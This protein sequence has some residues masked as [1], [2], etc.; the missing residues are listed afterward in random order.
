LAAGSGKK[1]L[2]IDRRPHIGVM[3][4]ISLIPGVLVHKYGRISSTNS[5]RSL[6]I[7]LF[8]PMA[9][10]EHRVRAS[11]EGQLVHAD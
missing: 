3:H 8:Y 2:I 4:T 1:V 6:P 10:Y 5:A 7:C 9:A 11:V